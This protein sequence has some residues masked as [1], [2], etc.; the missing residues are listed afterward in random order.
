MYTHTLSAAYQYAY[1][2]GYKAGA[3]CRVTKD[4]NPFVSAQDRIAWFNGFDEGRY[5]AGGGS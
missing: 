1:G 2:L 3:D 5:G 4:A